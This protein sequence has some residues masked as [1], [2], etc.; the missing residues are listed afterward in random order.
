MTTPSRWARARAS[1][2]FTLVWLVPAL[3]VLAFTVVVLARLL[4]DLPG[5]QAWLA[6]YPGS[7]P[8]PADAPVG[9][10]AW[11]NWQHFL[12][13]FFVLFIVR[14]GWQLRQRKRP[15][16]LWVRTTGPFRGANP[17][18]R[19]GLPLWFHLS[20]DVLWVLNGLLFYALLFATGQWVRLVPTSWDVIPNAVSAGLQYAS[21]NW[22]V[23]NGWV[24]YNSL[25]LLSY[26]ATVFVAAP[27]ALATG[28]RLAPGFAAR[29]RPLDR[30]IPLA[31]TH[32][33]H[34]AVM[35]Y[36]VAFT[37]VHVTLVLATGALRNLNHMYAGRDDSSWWGVG[38]FAASIVLMAVA[39][40]LARPSLLARVA[41]LTGK[42]RN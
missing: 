7:T 38:I 20:I 1:R 4:R 28:I 23:E 39:W 25:Q 24:N 22:P 26:F 5:V 12:N 6:L 35:V 33:A 42:V 36:F 34:W 13:S 27:L 11:A 3:V 40:M 2:W 30:V 31:V 21:L 14:T 17:P 15:E 19:I 9:F 32:T 16:H 29:L 37:I 18:I 10:P 41:V 8:L